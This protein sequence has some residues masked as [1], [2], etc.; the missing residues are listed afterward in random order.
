M[1]V[2]EIYRLHLNLQSF[3][4]TYWYLSVSWIPVDGVHYSWIQTK[5][6]HGSPDSEFR[7]SSRCCKTGHHILLVINV[8]RKGPF[9]DPPFGPG[10]SCGWQLEGGTLSRKQSRVCWIFMFWPLYS[11][12]DSVREGKGQFYVLH[13]PQSTASSLCHMVTQ[14]LEMQITGHKVQT[15]THLETAALCPQG[16]QWHCLLPHPARGTTRGRGCLFLASLL[17]PS[18]AE[19]RKEGGAVQHDVR[20]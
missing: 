1:H 9:S 8:C 18:F 13:R 16:E 4:S 15:I 11:L 10:A 17:A 12:Q 3:T 2:I 14:Q 7:Q 5:M 20:A 6:G 19:E